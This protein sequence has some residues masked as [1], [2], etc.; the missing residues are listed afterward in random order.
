PAEAVA[1]GVALARAP[2]V[3]VMDAD[4]QHPPERIA[5]MMRRAS[6]K[7]ADLVIASRY[8]QDGDGRRIGKLRLFLSRGS[9]MVARL[10]FPS[11]L[12][13][14]TDPMSGFFMVRRDA[15]DPA[16]LRP[17]GFK[18]LLE[19]LVRTPSLRVAEVP[20]EFA[21]R[22]AGDSKASPKEA[23]RYLALVAGLRFGEGSRRITRFVAVGLSGLAVNTLALAAFTEWAGIH[24]LWSAVLATQAST[25]WNFAL[26]EVWVFKD[27][28]H[29]R[30][31]AFR[32]VSFWFM[33]NLALWVRGPALVL[34]TS[35]LGIHYV[36]SNLLT[37]G[38]LTVARYLFADTWIWRAASPRTSET[39][40]H[41]Y[42]IH[43]IISV[44]SDA[45]LPELK[46]FRVPQLLAPPTIRVR[47]GKVTVEN[48]VTDG[49]QLNRTVY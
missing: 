6:E 4:L 9:T 41:A 30:H 22:F 36:V 18:I 23:L 3:C 49:G 32:L 2:W 43:G 25:A 27:R 38:A 13:A 42:D 8:C 1:A 39:A 24:Y 17:R 40:P 14:V 11:R 12:K 37:L 21:E 47:I 44:E 7:D 31:A 34:L 19:V 28:E 48:T 10:A 45:A 15:V 16:A 33:N 26:T 35:G 5:D 29:G 20:F 46:K